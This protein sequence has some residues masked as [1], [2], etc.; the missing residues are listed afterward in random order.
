VRVK[1]SFRSKILA[2]IGVVLM[3]ASISIVGAPPAQAAVSGT[4]ECDAGSAYP[5]VGV[6]INSTNNAH[7]GFASW[8]RFSGQPH[9]ASYSKGDIASGESYK[10]HVGCGGTTSSW[11]QTAYSG[12]VTGGHDFICHVSNSPAQRVCFS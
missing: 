12:T 5:V 4:V 1:N 3:A 2:P 10:V 7:D 9:R 8:S 6:W 11:G